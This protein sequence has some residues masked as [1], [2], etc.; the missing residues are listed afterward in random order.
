MS[1]V[2]SFQ[3]I[4]QCKLC[5]RVSRACLLEHGR[6]PCSRVVLM[7]LPNLRVRVGSPCSGMGRRGGADGAI[8]TRVTSSFC[9]FFTA[10]DTAGGQQL[11][12]I[13]VRRAFAVCSLVFTPCE[14]GAVH[15]NRTQVYTRDSVEMLNRCRLSR[16][17]QWQINRCA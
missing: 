15:P 13:D 14:S 16:S 4:A 10:D 2:I 12:L 8:W 1:G 3:I 17:S 11:Q 5:Y 9:I 6:V 7:V